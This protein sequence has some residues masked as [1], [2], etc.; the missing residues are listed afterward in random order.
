MQSLP[1]CDGRRIPQIGFGTAAIGNWQQDDD[2]V[3]EVVSKAIDAGYR[4]FDTASLYG[5]ERSVGKAIRASGLPRKDFFVTTKVWDTQQGYDNTL[6]AMEQS[7]KRLDMDYV[8]LYLIHWP[9]PEKTQATW[10]AMELLHHEGKA[11]SLGLSNFRKV[12]IQQLFDFAEIKPVYNQLELHPYLVQQPLVEYC[13]SKKMVVSCW[14]PL[15]SGSWSGV[16]D[17]DKPVND[18]AVIEIA[19]AH[20]VTAGQVILKWN[21]QQG[22]IVIPKAESEKHMQDNLQLDGFK[23]TAD[24]I[25]K[26]DSLN[27]DVRFGADP[28]TATEAN[29]QTPVPD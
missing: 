1:L 29:L 26:I 15:G 21:V 13:E 16:K 19:N 6:T 7:L 22:R 17:A 4:H 10:Q 8:D 14:S 5:N 11:K 27:R 2:Y 23:L 18:D 25:K 20:D 28:A 24:E 9:F 3:T 12:D